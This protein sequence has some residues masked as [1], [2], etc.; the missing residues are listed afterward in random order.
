MDRIQ[1]AIA[2]ARTIRLGLGL[3]APETERPSARP[4]VD[5]VVASEPDRS[6]KRTAS[7][8]AIPAIAP[9]AA[10]LAAHRIVAHSPGAD[11]APFDVL[12]TRVLQQ[13]GAGNWTRLAVTSPGP[14]CGKST[15][16]LNLAYSLARR[17]DLRV[18]LL[19]LDLRRP[20]LARMIGHD[21]PQS[22]DA[23]LAEDAELEAQMVRIDA[24]FALIPATAPVADPSGRLQSPAMTAILSQIEDRYAPDVL[25]FDLPPLAVGD[26]ALAF[27]PST[28][29]ALLVAAAAQT[30][31][32]EADLGEKE[33][34]RHTNVLGVVLN[35]CAHPG[36]GAG[37]GYGYDY[38]DDGSRPAA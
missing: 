8:D 15:V 5:E 30:T 19:D 9:D 27:L 35:K 38:G 21:G 2:R 10:T 25:I 24:R 34:A 26:D 11:A 31:L 36:P 6:A 18:M 32:G 12:R 29:C 13:M 33:L 1:A 23:A 28:D 22:I 20:A 37:Y 16:A 17:A 4:A 14:G 3:A 7:W